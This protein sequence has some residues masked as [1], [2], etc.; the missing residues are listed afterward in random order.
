[1]PKGKGHMSYMP[2]SGKTFGQRNGTMSGSRGGT[3]SGSSLHGGA[4]DYKGINPTGSTGHRRREGKMNSC[5]S[6]KGSG[7]Y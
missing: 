2:K 3:P 4:S 5:G 6:H 7:S 1:M